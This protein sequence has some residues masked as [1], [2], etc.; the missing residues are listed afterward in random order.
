MTPGC[1][2]LCHPPVNLTLPQGGTELKNCLVTGVAP[3]ST[4]FLISRGEKHVTTSTRS[5]HHTPITFTVTSTG[6]P[7]GRRCCL[8]VIKASLIRKRRT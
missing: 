2:N 3:L 4:P 1:L 5:G 8:V 7:S 6:S